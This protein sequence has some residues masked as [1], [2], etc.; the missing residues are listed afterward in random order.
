MRVLGKKLIFIV[1]LL[2][3]TNL[4][5]EEYLLD[6]KQKCS[7][8]GSELKYKCKKTNDYK[9]YIYNDDGIWKARTLDN[10][11]Q[12]NF[13]VLRDD[14][15]ILVLEQ[16]TGYSGNQ[17]IY[18]MKKNNRFYLVQVA[19]SDILKNNETTTKQ[20]I[21]IKTSESDPS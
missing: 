18:I 3:S 16:W 5:A 6:F 11:H 14:E 21:F 12:A 13:K 17:V 1:S 4:W 2:L 8:D 15:N 7:A 9:H 19:Y 20:G 10:M